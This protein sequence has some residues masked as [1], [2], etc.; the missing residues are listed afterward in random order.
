MAGVG[1][2]QKQVI[3]W[4]VGVRFVSHVPLGRLR[5]EQSVGRRGHGDGGIRRRADGRWEATIDLGWVNGKRARKQR[6]QLL[7]CSRE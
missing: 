3:G 5:R 7:V 2:R 6:L 1:K 4:D